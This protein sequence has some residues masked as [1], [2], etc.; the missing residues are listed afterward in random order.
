MTSSTPP[1]INFQNPVEGYLRLTADGEWLYQ[2]EPITHPGLLHILESNYG[3]AEDGRYLVHLH[4]PN[5]T[6]KVAVQVEDTPYFVR[7]V[8]WQPNGTGLLHL[9]DGTQEVLDP[10]K[11]TMNEEGFTYTFVKNGAAEA[12]FLRQAEIRMADFVE[13]KDG[14]V[15]L[16]VAGEWTPLHM[17]V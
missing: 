13:E 3:R 2:G 5:G 12:K 9:N 14:N 4:L 10:H 17:R 11:V 7:D 6:Q 15:G 16:V 1:P 8:D